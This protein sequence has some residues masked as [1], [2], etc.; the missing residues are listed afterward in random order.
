MR[1]LPRRAPQRARR[2]VLGADRGAYTAELAVAL[3]SLLFVLACALLGVGVAGGSLQCQDAARAGARALARGELRQAVTAAAK[4]AAP[5]GASIQLRR[6]AGTAEVRCKAAIQM[7][8][9][10]TFTVKARAVAAVE[11]PDSLT[12][13]GEFYRSSGDTREDGR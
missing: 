7:F 1:Q 8:G 5:Q 6:S 3:P 10:H 9:L 4:D 11:S 2:V 12:P 13:A